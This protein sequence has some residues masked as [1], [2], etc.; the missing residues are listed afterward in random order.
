MM[1][2]GKRKKEMLER[3][4]RGGWAKTEKAAFNLF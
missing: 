2:G 1:D 4:G 3:L